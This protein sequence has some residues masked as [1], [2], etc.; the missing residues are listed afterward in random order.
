MGWLQHLA[1]GQ[2]YKAVAVAAVLLG[3]LGRFS[4]RTVHVQRWPTATSRSCRAGGQRAAKSQ[5]QSWG[6][7]HME[8]V[9]GYPF[10]QGIAFVSKICSPKCSSFFFFFFNNL[11]LILGI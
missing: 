11:K 2:P 3:A 6:I 10:S 1:L 4:S 8:W 5:A 7:V 9:N